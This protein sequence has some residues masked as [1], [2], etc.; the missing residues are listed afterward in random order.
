MKIRN[1][2]ILLCIPLLLQAK[3]VSITGTAMFDAVINASDVVVVDYYADWCGPCKILGPILDELSEN[4]DGAVTFAKVNV[5]T[6]RQLASMA[7]ARSIPLVLFYKGGK[8]VHTQTGLIRK[9]EYQQIIDYIVA[10]EPIAPVVELTVD[11]FEKESSKKGALIIDVRTKGEYA[12]GHLKNALLMPIDELQRRLG[13]LEKYKDAPVYLYCRS[14]NRSSS[15]A[16]ILTQAG[17]TNVHNM[18]RGVITWI[19]AGKPV[20]TP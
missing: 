19:A 11:E 12:Q 13:E 3:V 9:E 1:I 18:S 15:A 17:F 6:Q 2:L 7:R 5:D 8:A 10:M 4:Y 20:E 16:Q 14:G